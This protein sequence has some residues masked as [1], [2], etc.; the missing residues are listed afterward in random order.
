M[1]AQTS[2]RMPISTLTLAAAEASGWYMPNYNL[3]E[4]LYW[5]K[6]KGCNFI[7]SPCLSGS[8]PTPVSSEFC[9]V[10]KAI[11]CDLEQ[12]VVSVCGTT[13]STVTN[14]N[15]N[16]FGDGKTTSSDTFSDGCPIP[17]TSRTCAAGGQTGYM[18]P[19]YFGSDSACFTTS[20]VYTYLSSYGYGYVGECFQFQVK[21]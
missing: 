1:I 9:G 18:V 16:Y 10:A 11:G 6:N 5:G 15:W 17:N 12:S 8:P 4:P 19:E 3:A 21:Y 14:A 20:I 7:N 2:N 13:T